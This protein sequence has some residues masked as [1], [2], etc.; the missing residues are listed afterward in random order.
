MTAPAPGDFNHSGEYAII[1]PRNPLTPAMH[2][3]LIG[4]LAIV[5]YLTTSTLLGWRLAHG[6]T[7]TLSSRSAIL[8]LGMG[9]VILHAALLYPAI[10][11]HEGMKLGF[12][13]AASLIGWLI[14]A[15]LLVA[16]VRK[17]VE[18]LGIVLMPIAALSL[19]LERLYPNAT[20]VVRT[21]GSWQLDTH[22]LVSILAYSL[23]TIAA[24]QAILL[25]IQ[26]Q[27]LRNRH[28]GGFIRALPPLQIMEELLFQMI[29]LG[30][31]L[32][33]LSLFSGILFIDD[34]FAQHLVHKTVLSI[35]AWLVFG[36]LLWG[37]WHFG[38][39]GRT[40]IRWTLGGFVTLMLA[41]FGSKLVLELILQRA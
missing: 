30:F 27:H 8:V 1:H 14:A 21:S 17:P 3:T 28:P 41:Y 7:E 32:L 6:S 24:V 9:A 29:G 36:V 22:I 39:R 34:I 37:R 35:C 10:I 25:A 38:W 20:H 11:S 26:D 18:N 5:L 33:S 23:L 12:F 2:I 31:L 13:N 15:L 40:A 4:I 16:A 19:A